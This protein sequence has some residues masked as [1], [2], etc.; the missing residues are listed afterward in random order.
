MIIP[1]GLLLETGL[2]GS[3]FL[4]LTVCA[5]LTVVLPIDND[6]APTPACTI[7]STSAC[8][9]VVVIRCVWIWHIRPSSSLV[10]FFPSHCS[11]YRSYSEFIHSSRG[12]FTAV[13]LLVRLSFPKLS[14]CHAHDPCLSR[15]FCRPSR[16]TNQGAF[17]D[18]EMPLAGRPKERE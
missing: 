5:V 12:L 1:M 10:F 6:G 11:G 18:A 16:H 17:P 2:L 14:E 15:T 3:Y 4:R 13:F 7:G 9:L 8:S